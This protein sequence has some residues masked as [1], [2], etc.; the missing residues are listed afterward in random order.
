M[1]SICG[2]NL[3]K[4]SPHEGDFNIYRLCFNQ[5]G[6]IDSYEVNKSDLGWFRWI[7]D[8]LDGRTTSWLSD[9]RS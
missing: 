7:F 8:A 9:R 6:R 2:G 3:P 5:G 1:D 4:P